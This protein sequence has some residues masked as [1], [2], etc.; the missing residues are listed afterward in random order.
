[1]FVVWIRMLVNQ[2][3]SSMKV[4][5]MWIFGRTLLDKIPNMK[6]LDIWR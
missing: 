3:A 6:K 2:G 5:E 4:V 1:M